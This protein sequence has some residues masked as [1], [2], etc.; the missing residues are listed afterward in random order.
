MFDSGILKGSIDIGSDGLSGIT[1]GSTHLQN[2]AFFNGEI[3][4]LLIYNTEFDDINRK[5]IEN[6]LM[7]KYAPPV[8]LGYDIRVSGFAIQQL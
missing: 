6:Y 1:L 7:D 4:E 8:N 5:T 2:S 3:A